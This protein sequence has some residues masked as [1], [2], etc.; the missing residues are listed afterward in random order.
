MEYFRL[1]GLKS[2]PFSSTPDPR[3]FYLSDEYRECLQ[4]LEISIRL[5]RGLNVIPEMMGEMA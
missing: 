5:R 4:K 1:L 2:E 3:F